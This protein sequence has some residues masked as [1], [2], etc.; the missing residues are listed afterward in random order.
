MD[1]KAFGKAIVESPGRIPG[2]PP[3]NL[4][5]FTTMF[6]ERVGSICVHGPEEVPVILLHLSDGCALDLC[7]IALLTLRWIFVAAY[8]DSVKCEEM[9]KVFVPYEMITRIILSKRSASERRIGFQLEKSIP[10]LEG[11]MSEEAR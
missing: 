10:A 7:H 3:F 5:F 9:D 1:D 4:E 2:G 11:G 8:R 6:R